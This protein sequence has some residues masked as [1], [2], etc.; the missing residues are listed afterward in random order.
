MSS[1][2]RKKTTKEIFEDKTKLIM[3][4]IAWRCSFYRENPQRFVKDYLGIDLRLFQKILLYAMIHNNFFIFIASRGL[5]KTYLVSLYCCVKAILFPKSK[6]VIAASVRT[7]GNE[8]LLKIQDELMPI[9]SNLRYEILS[10]Y[11]S[12]NNACIKFKNGSWIKVVTAGDSARGN[13]ATVVCVDEFVKVDEIVINT[14]LKKFLTSERE[15]RFLKKEE[16]KDYPKERNQQFFMSSA[17]MKDTWSFR[18]LQSFAAQLLDDTKKYFTCG[19]PYQIAIKERLLNREQVEDEFS[20]Q[21]FNETIWSMEMECLWFGDS[22][23]AFFKYSDL[24]KCQKLSDSFLSLE[25][26]NKY[27]IK[28]PP[29]ELKE[30]RIL[31]VDVALMGS[32]KRNNDAASIQIN[33]GILLSDNTITG[34]I[35][36]IENHEGMTTDELGLRIMRMYYDYKCTDLVIDVKGIGLGV[37]DFIIKDQF[38]PS[39]NRTYEALNCCNNDEY[40]D[41][42]KVKGAPK[43]IWAILGSASFNNEMCI[44]LR[45]GI[46]KGKINLLISDQDCEEVLKANV[47][48]FNKL[49]LSEQTEYKMPYIQTALLINELIH[50]EYEVKGTNIRVYEKSGARKDR[51]SSLGYNF[52]IQNQIERK[53]KPKK[54]TEQKLIEQFKVRQSTR[55]KMFGD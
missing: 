11:I 26:Y 43:V 52:Y 51:Y 15:P 20:E 50:L 18:K 47:K 8:C 40:S 6:I 35:V 17:F 34:N 42:C 4:I 32:K 41:R 22:D 10:C 44:S 31:S 19:L 13:R 1:N 21:D 30:K 37:F 49:Q 38:D 55:H 39:T 29:L 28:I 36:Y 7:Q 16:Y 25:Q 23:G 14:V 2:V 12:Q 46:Q 33:R 48:N 5:G 3:D 24:C 54:T 45:D 9:S 53:I 27:K